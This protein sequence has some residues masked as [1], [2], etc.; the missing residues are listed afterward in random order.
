MIILKMISKKNSSKIK[1]ALFKIKLLKM[2]I[3]KFQGLYLISKI[4]TVN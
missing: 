4:K 1:K 3:N 2:N